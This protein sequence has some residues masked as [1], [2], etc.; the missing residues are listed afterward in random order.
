M[1]L[2]NSPQNT[3]DNH[4][5]VFSTWRAWYVLLMAV[6]LVQL[7]LYSYLTFLFA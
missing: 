7:I 2:T 1:H 4:P 3:S 6:L 5:P